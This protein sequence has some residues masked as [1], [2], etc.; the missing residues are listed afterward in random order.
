MPALDLENIK[1]A[2]PWSA[3]AARMSVKW[4]DSAVKGADGQWRQIGLWTEQ[5]EQHRTDPT[6]EITA[7]TQELI[8]GAPDLYTKLSRITSYIQKNVRYFVCAARNRRI[9][10]ALRRRYFSQSLWR[11]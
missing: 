3:L 10:S 4:G 5:L 8:A 11:L 7:K 9:S 1:S 6:P 2:P